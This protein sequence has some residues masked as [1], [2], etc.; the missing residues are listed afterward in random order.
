MHLPSSAVFRFYAELNDFLPDRGAGGRERVYRF[1]GTPS[2]K[3]AFEAQGV[4]HTE[5]ELIVV[6]GASVGFDYS[7]RNGD[8]VALYPVFE[9]LDV[10]PLLRVRDAPLRRPRFVCDVHLGKLARS[11]RLLGCD[12][13]YRNNAC[14]HEIV[15]QAQHEQ[16][17][18]L[19][20]D[21]RLLQHKV[22]THG[23]WVRSTDPSGQVG[24]VV[25]RF[26]LEPADL[27]PFSR[28]LVCN[29]RL[30][31]VRKADVLEQLE[32]KTREFYTEFFQCTDCR[33]IYWRGSH[34]ERLARRLEHRAAAT[35]G[36]DPLP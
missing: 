31:S 25:R 34:Y 23:Y 28:C 21:R 12:T 8:R 26:Q 24:E 35:S 19:T 4:P 30:Q 18:V 2:V 15:A 32:P 13:A 3:G 36:V 27:A 14:D 17:I 20:R 9:S 10:R 6:N 29:G 7:L 16:R 22:L 5:V 11:L 33:R 1:T